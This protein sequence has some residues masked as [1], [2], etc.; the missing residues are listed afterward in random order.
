MHLSDKSCGIALG[1]KDNFINE[2]KAFQIA[3]NEL[4]SSLLGEWVAR[5]GWDHEFDKCVWKVTNVF[6]NGLKGRIGNYWVIDA[7]SQHILFNI[8]WHTSD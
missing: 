3:K 5:L 4:T 8:Q 1:V 6:Q 7:V 2:S